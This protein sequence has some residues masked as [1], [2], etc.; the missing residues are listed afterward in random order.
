[1]NKYLQEAAEKIKKVRLA[2]GMTQDEFSDSFNRRVPREIKINRV[3][4]SK[5]ERACLRMPVDKYLKAIA[6]NP[7]DNPLG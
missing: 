7:P 6:M 2:L 1:M 4:L 3:L 5:Y